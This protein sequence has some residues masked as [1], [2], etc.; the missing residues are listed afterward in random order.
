MIGGIYYL[1]GAN[2][3]NLRTKRNRMKFTK[4]IVGLRTEIITD[5]T[6]TITLLAEFY[7]IMLSSF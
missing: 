5:K 3:F 2:C 1:G 6:L 4:S 7:E